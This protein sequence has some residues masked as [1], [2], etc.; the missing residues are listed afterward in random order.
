MSSSATILL[1]RKVSGTAITQRRTELGMTQAEAAT[2]AS[3]SLA[4]WRRFEQSPGLGYRSDTIRGVSRALK[5]RSGELADL[6][7]GDA[8]TAAAGQSTAWVPKWN[9]L[10]K[11]SW[12]SITPRMAAAIQSSLDMARDM[13]ENSLRDSDVDPEENP[14]LGELDSRIFIAVGENRPWY[15]AV[16]GRLEHLV[17]AMNQGRLID[18]SC[19]CFAD[20]AL[21]AAAVRDAAETWDD[22]LEMGT[23]Q[24]LDDNLDLAP[25]ED[26]DELTAQEVE[27]AYRDRWSHFEDELDDR[28][29]YREWDCVFAEYRKTRLLLDRRP[30]Q[31]WFDEPDTELDEF[32]ALA[33]YNLL[34]QE[35]TG[36]RMTSADA[37]QPDDPVPAG[38]LG[39]E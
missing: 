26:G 22:N 12:N 10:W 37:A 13:L 30:P 9:S 31:T 8:P 18:E 23:W 21:F 25:D 4:T 17:K 14:V 24:D 7:N 15:R 27:D 39:G 34:A 11:E 38:D 6:L 19:E 5:L 20:A 35:L 16:V 28:M 1:M 29:P 32:R 3:I 2:R 36:Y 33:P